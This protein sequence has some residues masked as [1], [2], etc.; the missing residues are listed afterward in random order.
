MPQPTPTPASK[1]KRHR[2]KP[3]DAQILLH[4]G[5]YQ[6]PKVNNSPLLFFNTLLS[7]IAK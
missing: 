4:G 5:K 3:T 7:C 2:R 1:L 6:I